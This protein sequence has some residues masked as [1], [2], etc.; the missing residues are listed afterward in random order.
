MHIK[1]VVSSMQFSYSMDI[2]GLKNELCW[3]RCDKLAADN[4]EEPSVKPLEVKVVLGLQQL[5]QLPSPK[6]LHVKFAT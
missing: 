4:L 5:N 1:C 6:A 2:N 3:N